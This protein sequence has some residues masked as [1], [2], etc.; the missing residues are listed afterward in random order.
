MLLLHV[1]A[2]AGEF[3]HFGNLPDPPPTADSGRDTNAGD[4]NDTHSNDTNTHDT[5]PD[6]TS[7]CLAT[8]CE[9]AGATCGTID[10]G[11]G[12]SLECG[13]CGAWT[14]CEA[15]VCVTAS[16]VPTEADSTDGGGRCDDLAQAWTARGINVGYYPF[17][18]LADTTQ[19][20]GD[21]DGAD[22]V[23]FTRG[24]SRAGVILQ[25]I[26]AGS[27]VGLSSIGPYYDPGADCLPS[28]QCGDADVEA[29]SASTPPPPAGDLRVLL[30][31]CV[32]R[33]QPHAGLDL[34]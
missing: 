33:R 14:S 30:G 34:R 15:N 29:C 31:V 27:Y 4:T 16:C 22:G 8:S 12:A 20:S 28:G 21:Y 11:C 6:D 17:K 13:T 24:A 9:S 32:R 1:V 23:T 25:V 10:D 5:S 3:P 18:V 7:P 19:Y 2:C 26:P